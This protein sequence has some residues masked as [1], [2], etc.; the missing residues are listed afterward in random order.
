MAA[1]REVI[2][3]SGAVNSPHLLQLSGIGP[4]ELLNS[5]DI[6]VVKELP[7]VGQNLQDHLQIRTVY[8][9][10]VPTLNEEIN[11][12]F[13]RMLIGVQYVLTR[14]GPMSMGASQVAIFCKTRPEIDTPDIQYHFQP[15][16]ADK[17][18]IVMHPFPGI[19]M[20]VI[21]DNYELLPP[22][23]AGALAVRPG[24]RRRCRRAGRRVPRCVRAHPSPAARGS[25]RAAFGQLI[26]FYRLSCGSLSC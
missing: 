2:L 25:G 13:R 15:L 4:G 1:R 22:G 21:D 8:E 23:E 16:S 14:G 3:C 17:P 19:T 5:L 26:S 20:G 18:G 11:N 12:F 6:P 7:G 10:N 24:T 9:V